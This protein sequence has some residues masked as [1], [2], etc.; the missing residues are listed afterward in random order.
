MD[1]DLVS[2]YK[3]DLPEID[4][5][6]LDLHHGDVWYYT[7]GIPENCGFGFSIAFIDCGCDLS[8]FELV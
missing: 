6:I 1:K 8:K 4:C 5:G 7:Q 2:L 3:E